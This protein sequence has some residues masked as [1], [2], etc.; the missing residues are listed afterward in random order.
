MGGRRLLTCQRSSKALNSSR[1]YRERSDDRLQVRRTL[2][3]IVVYV[4]SKVFAFANYCSA[5]NTRCSYPTVSL[6]R[7]N[8]KPRGAAADL[9]N[10]SLSGTKTRAFRK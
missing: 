5:A 1:C 9:V 7:M 2:L 3:R 4:N 8:S 6:R 10:E